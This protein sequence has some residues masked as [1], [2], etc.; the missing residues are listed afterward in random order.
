MKKYVLFLFSSTFLT[1]S[2]NLYAQGTAFTYQGRL[3]DNGSPVSGIFD[4]RFAIYDS[5]A[6]GALLGGP[7]TNAATGVTNGLFT[8]TL[9]FGNEFP[10]T[11]RWL[12]IAVQTNGGGG[13]TTLTPRQQLTP[14]PYAIFANTASNV[15]GTLAAAQIV[16]VL[17]NN[18]ANVN[19]TGAFSG[20]GAGLTNLNGAALKLTNVWQ[21]TGNSGTTPGV[22]FLGT[23][24][25]QPVEL[26]AYGGRALRLEPGGPSAFQADGVPTGAPNVIGGSPSNLVASGVV[27][28]VIGGGGATNY[29]GSTVANSIGA[30]SDFSTIGGGSGNRILT[31]SGSSAI[32]G[33]IYNVIA[34]NSS[35][36]VISGGYQN[37][38]EPDSSYSSIGGGEQNMT[39]SSFS[40]MGG[41]GF[42]LIGPNSSYSIVAGGSNNIVQSNSPGSIIAG[43]LNNGVGSGAAN[44]FVAGGIDNFA[45]GNDSFVAGENSTDVNSG[46]AENNSFVWG[47]GTR[48]CV[49]QGAHTF[50][51]LA[52][53]GVYFY[54]YLDAENPNYGAFLAANSTSWAAIS[55]R[56]A[57]K[58]F[59]PVDGVSVLDKLA[60]I[61]IQEWNYKWEKD[62]DVPN[63]GPMAQDFKHTFY[64]GRDDKSITTLEFDGVELAAIQGLNEKLKEKDAEIQKLE[65]KAGEVDSLEKRVSDLEKMV[66]RISA[67]K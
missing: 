64:P 2:W 22:N 23:V 29:E 47:D 67:N 42:N 31:N 16:G 10:G 33:G 15:T 8:A 65:E 32:G 12:E 6:N 3:Q 30:Y 53:G 20:N 43:G 34:A 36:A 13:F 40:V 18:A 52:T 25:N 46:R 45:G 57:K 39:G 38:I 1:V 11:A 28:A 37:I 35:Y 4:L 14:T 9:D 24:D 55:D 19:L 60:A 21:T 66:Q 48:K 17:T 27:G 51:A 61:P 50:V 58:N 26:W 5:L 54:T 62:S 49:S 63:I 44:A 56:N 7:L 41:G 59:Q